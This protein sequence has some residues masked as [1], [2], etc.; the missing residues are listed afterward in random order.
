MLK[1]L[2][3]KLTIFIYPNSCMKPILILFL[4][5]FNF[6]LFGQR[7]VHYSY[8]ASGNRIKREIILNKLQSYSERKKNIQKDTSFVSEKLSGQIVKIYPNPTRGILTVCFS[9]KTENLTGSVQICSISGQNILSMKISSPIVSIDLTKNIP[10][11]YL[12]KLTLNGESSVWKII[13]E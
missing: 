11:T 2:F 4:I 10:G 13:K 9:G 1:Y 6:Y 3:S 5:G 8:D 7:Q 12:L